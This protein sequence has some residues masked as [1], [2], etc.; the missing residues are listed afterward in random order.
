MTKQI[1]T[2]NNEELLNL[3]FDNFPILDIHTDP[4]G[5]VHLYTNLDEKLAQFLVSIMRHNRPLDFYQ[6]ARL[7]RD[8]KHDEFLYLCEPIHIDAGGQVFNFQHRLKAFLLTCQELPEFTMP[9]EICLGFEFPGFEKLDKT[10]PRTRGQDMKLRNVAY[11]NF[12]STAVPYIVSFLET[13]DF[14][15]E[16]MRSITSS[17]CLE[18]LKNHPEVMGYASQIASRQKLLLPASWL[19]ALRYVCG[20]VDQGDAE[21]FI[22]QQIVEERKLDDGMPAYAFKLWAEGKGRQGPVTNRLMAYTLTEMFLRFRRGESVKH[23]RVVKQ[24]PDLGL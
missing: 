20:L 21:T 8:M 19:V 11:Y 4:F 16:M 5:I 17:E 1:N 23:C 12:Q 7:K 3:L 14:T 6:V 22:I 13:K 9:V 15:A 10:K 24:M 18:F 2:T